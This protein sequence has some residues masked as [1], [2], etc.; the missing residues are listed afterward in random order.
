M[1]KARRWLVRG[2]MALIVAGCGG[3]SAPGATGV[4]GDADPD[5]NE[6]TADGG[7]AAQACQELTPRGCACNP[8]APDCIVL[9]DAIQACGWFDAPAPGACTEGFP[10]P[11]TFGV[12]ECDCEGR[13]CAEGQ[14]CRRIHETVSGGFYYQNRCYAVC[15]SDGDCATGQS[16][17]PNRFGAPVCSVVECRND[18]DCTEDPCGH[19]VRH[20]WQGFQGA[21]WRALPMCVYQG[22]PSG[23]RCDSGGLPE[24]PTRYSVPSLSDRAGISGVHV[25]HPGDAAWD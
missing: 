22:A 18:A 25:C 11:G 16:C 17:L 15:A 2:A 6:A 21:V 4:S 10:A 20:E 7:G 13:S 14:T 12:D 19:C 8:E 5:A 9:S 24:Y 23:G 1:A 3:A